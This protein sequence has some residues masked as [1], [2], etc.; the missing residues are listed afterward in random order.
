MKSGGVE[1]WKVESGDSKS[2]TNLG[3]EEGAES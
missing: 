2:N 1:V 3:G